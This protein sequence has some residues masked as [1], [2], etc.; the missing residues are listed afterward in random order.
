MYMLTNTKAMNKMMAELY[1]KG[2]ITTN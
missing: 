1:G 2:N